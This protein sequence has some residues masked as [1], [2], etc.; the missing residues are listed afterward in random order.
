MKLL[1]NKVALI[2][3]AGS[4]IG[5]GIAHLFAE[6]GAHVFILEL[7]PDA[8]SRV[9]SAIRE[10]GRSALAFPTDV[11]R[12]DTI[13]PAVEDA[14]ERFGRIDILI[15]NAGIYPR[16][17][18]LEM[19]EALWDEMHD[20]NLKGTYHVT[21]LVL[22]HMVGRKSGKI[23]N[24]SSIN[25]H[26]GKENLTHYTSAKGAIIGL[27]RSLAREAG[28][29]WVYVNCITPGAIEVEAEK[30]FLDPT[31][32][33]EGFL[34]LQCLQRRLQPLDVAR[35][36]LFLASELSD[37]MTGQTLNVDGGWYMY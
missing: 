17:S 12:P 1:E 27:T 34:A 13:A 20:V 10:R 19:T 31:D 21:K 29:H 24:I 28:P 8:G 4:G 9:A 25:F 22:P 11:R 37:G 6:S 5:E 2:T 26:L 15:N 16:R 33:S 18:F 32:T 7:N 3:G 35:V 23:V 30:R 36:C 14:I